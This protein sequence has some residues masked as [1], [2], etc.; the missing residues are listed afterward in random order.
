M[1][2]LHKS[3]P[4]CYSDIHHTNSPQ[5]NSALR[6]GGYKAAALYPVSA[7]FTRFSVFWLSAGVCFVWMSAQTAII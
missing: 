6:S 2:Q 1:R 4:F 3:A 5:I 7:A